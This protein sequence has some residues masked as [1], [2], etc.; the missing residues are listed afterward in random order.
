MFSLAELLILFSIFYIIIIINNMM[1]KYKQDQLFIKQ[2]LIKKQEAMKKQEAFKKQE[3]MKKQEA[4]K[5]QEDVKK[6]EATYYYDGNYNNILLL[7]ILECLNNKNEP[8]NKIINKIIKKYKHTDK[9]DKNT[10]YEINDIFNESSID[11]QID[12]IKL[13][14]SFDNIKNKQYL[15]DNIFIGYEETFDEL[16]EYAIKNNMYDLCEFVLESKS[17]KID[18]DKYIKFEQIINNKE[19]YV[20][21]LKHKIEYEYHN[22][23]D[24]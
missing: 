19:I 23:K 18:E 9:L 22:T 15:I 4:F 11:K 17:C 1:N 3:V 5:K 10:K 7:T 21:F 2:E 24:C 16:L 14:F 8:I 12:L 6:Q 20:L 13:V